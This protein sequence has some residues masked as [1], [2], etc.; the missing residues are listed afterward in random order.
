MRR[1][2]VEAL[3]FSPHCGADP[4]KEELASDWIS[5]PFSV[6]KLRCEQYKLRHL[7]R[8]LLESAVNDLAGSTP[9]YPSLGSPGYRSDSVTSV[10]P[11]TH[12]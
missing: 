7:H 10:M 3:E 2:G 9:G 11:R 12:C 8:Q 5:L 1:V 6:C 4:F